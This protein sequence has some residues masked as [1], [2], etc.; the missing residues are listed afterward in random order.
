MSL[1]KRMKNMN[2][3]CCR[4]GGEEKKRKKKII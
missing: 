2:F 1:L 4:M 3:M